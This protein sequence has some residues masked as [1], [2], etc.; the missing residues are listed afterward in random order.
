MPEV[1]CLTCDKC[2]QA[3]P[4][5]NRHRCPSCMKRNTAIIREHRQELQRMG[6]CLDCRQAAEPKRTRCR[7]CLDVYCEA[8]RVRGIKN[9]V[10]ALEAY[11][12]AFCACCGENELLM[13]TLDHIAQDGADRRREGEGSGSKVYGKL[14]RLGYP[15]GFRVLCRNCNF[16]VYFA[17]DHLCPHRTGCFSRLVDPSRSGA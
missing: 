1:Y 16:A 14:R 13:L 17:P 4:T 12:G 5:P 10:E 8:A 11:G 3:N 15:S 6:L 7:R 9:K 2:R